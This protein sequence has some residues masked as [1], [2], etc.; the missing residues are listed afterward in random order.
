MDWS[1]SYNDICAQLRI[2]QIHEMEVR[3]RVEQAHTVMVTGEMPSSGS[4]CHLPLDKAITH[5]NHA[6]DALNAVQGEVDRLSGIKREMEQAMGGFTGLRNRIIYERKANGKKYKEIAEELG[7][8]PQYLR[9]V[10]SRR[11]YK[12]PTQSTNAS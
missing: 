10:A 9:E 5:Y 6:V 8:T 7:Y 2:V 4:Y 12:Q 11:T 3:R 1:E